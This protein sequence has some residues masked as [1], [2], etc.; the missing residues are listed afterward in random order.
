[1]LMLLVQY[2]MAMSVCGVNGLGMS[3][4]LVAGQAFR[5]VTRYTPPTG[6]TRRSAVSLARVPLLVPQIT[7]G[8]EV[9]GPVSC[10]RIEACDTATLL[11]TAAH[12][13]SD[14]P[15]TP[16]H[17]SFTLQCTKRRGSNEPLRQQTQ[18]FA[19]SKALRITPSCVQTMPA[20]P[21]SSGRQTTLATPTRKS[22]LHSDSKLASCVQLPHRHLSHSRLCFKEGDTALDMARQASAP[23]RNRST[24]KYNPFYQVTYDQGLR[25]LN[26]LKERMVEG[27]NELHCSDVAANAMQFF[28]TAE[29]VDAMEEIISVLTKHGMPL[30]VEH[31]NALLRGVG[32]TGE[33]DRAYSIL[34]R[35]H[36]YGVA[37]DEK[38]WQAVV[39]MH[40]DSGQLHY[41]HQ[42]LAGISRLKT[43]LTVDDYVSIMKAARR[44]EAPRFAEQILR[45]VARHHTHV[46][47]SM[48]HPLLHCYA[49]LGHATE[50]TRVFRDMRE[51]SGPPDGDAHAYVVQAYGRAGNCEHAIKLF[52]ELK[53]VV[54][55]QG[56]QITETAYVCILDALVHSGR[57][58]DV[59]VYYQE[60][61]ASGIELTAL[62]FNKVM[63]AYS[64]QGDVD[65]SRAFLDEMQARGVAASE[66]TYQSLMYA[67]AKANLPEVA[68][69]IL[70]EMEEQGV[71]PSAQS[72]HVLLLAYSFSHQHA[73]ARKVIDRMLQRALRPLP[74]SFNALLNMH[75]QGSLA[76]VE[77]VFQDMYKAH[78][79]AN[80]ITYNTVLKACTLN[81][82]LDVGEGLIDLMDQRGIAAELSTFGSLTGPYARQGMLSQ[83]LRTIQRCVDYGLVPNARMLAVIHS[84]LRRCPGNVKDRQK[85]MHDVLDIVKDA[86]EFLPTDDATIHYIEHLKHDA[87]HYN[88][89]EWQ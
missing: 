54:A 32:Y 76:D 72:F 19:E 88:I 69:E 9:K 43:S 84:G 81:N 63:K 17:R 67:A 41:E 46:P 83:L 53:A 28:S 11:S 24:P 5:I 45:I 64:H 74:V 20:L 65:K 3:T 29:A 34:E 79:P 37:P 15:R 22:Q 51:H 61:L 39:Q 80:A 8:M 52:E 89:A 50:C 57:F 40:K 73:P 66:V 38:S 25:Y 78:V 70:L 30:S 44:C 55:K 7:P 77:T 27:A 16:L 23:W 87:P 10:D 68:E 62:S 59:G 31:L 33:L 42:C 36:L 56:D 35:F 49:Q 21:R 48:W 75:A 26:Q 86:T 85:T 12:T 47:K 13:S 71:V 1:M 6:G 58:K 4:R 82:R 14:R 60:M 2:H 18:G